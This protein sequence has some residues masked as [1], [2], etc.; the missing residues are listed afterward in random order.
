VST[1]ILVPLDRSELGECG[2]A[3]AVALAGQ[4]DAVLRLVHVWTPRYAMAGDFA[5]TPPVLINDAERLAG[6]RYIETSVLAI[7]QSTALPVEG[8]L[9]EGMPTDAILGDV[10]TWR[11]D[12]IVM[13][14]HGRTGWSRAWLGS[15]AD[16]L[17]RLAQVPVLLVRPMHADGRRRDSGLARS[18]LVPLD[19]GDA[20]ECVLPALALVSAPEARVTL[21]AVVRPVVPRYMPAGVLADTINESAM[22]DLYDAERS[23]LDAVV[24][25]LRARLPAAQVDTRIETSDVAARA[26]LEASAGFDLVAVCT[27]TRA[28]PRRLL[29]GG[30]LDKLLRGTDTN[31]LVV[32]RHATADVEE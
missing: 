25:R 16:A 30:T 23:Y 7:R 22:T 13:S 17:I 32:R 6:E 11:P 12:I 28:G 3:H 15:V 2:L 18:L 4:T 31:L 29:H 20:A 1:R 27:R 5:V 8:H 26:I 9:L 14:S 19:G 10:H 24:P 21:L